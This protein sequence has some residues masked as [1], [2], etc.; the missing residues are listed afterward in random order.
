MCFANINIQAQSTN[1][2]GAIPGA[3]DVSPMGAATYTIPIEVVPG[4]QGMQPN[5]SIVYNSF[6][7]MGLLGMKWNLEGLSAISRCGQNPYYERQNPL[8]E[9]NITA[10]QFNERDRFEIDGERLIRLNNGTY[11]AVGGEYATEM[12]D[13][14][15]IVSYSGTIH[16]KDISEEG[17][18]FPDR[19]INQPKYFIAYTD[20]G[21]TIEY[22]NTNDS[23]QMMKDSENILSWYINKITDIDGNYMTFHY[24]KYDSSEVLINSIQ[25]TGNSGLQPYAKVQF[26][27][28]NLPDTLGANTY[29]V[30]GYSVAQTKLLES[31]L[32]KYNNEIVRKY[33]CEYNFHYGERTAHLQ[34]VIL[35]GYDENGNEEQLN[36][37]SISWGEQNTDINQEL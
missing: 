28:T 34:R 12:E 27:Y 37:T 20:D 24:I 18:I 3:I 35:F 32:V 9:S 22:G 30:E 15:R 31:I 19:V 25:Y 26:N 23:K 1:P 13:F 16:P 14:T 6:E 29:F 5:L 10:I 17:D 11:G 8:F 21:T 36:E 33:K 4:T 2:V 7:G